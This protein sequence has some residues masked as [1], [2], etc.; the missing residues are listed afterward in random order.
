MTSAVEFV[1][2]DLII[3]SAGESHWCKSIAGDPLAAVGH[4]IAHRIHDAD[5]KV[6]F[7]SG[8]RVKGI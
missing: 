1:K 3:L 5:N 7:P 8:N 4:F 6:T 2:D